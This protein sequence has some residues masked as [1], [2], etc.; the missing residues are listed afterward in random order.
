MQPWGRERRMERLWHRLGIGP[1]MPRTIY[2][3]PW[4]K[5]MSI[6]TWIALGF[7]ALAWIALVVALVAIP[8]TQRYVC[9]E[10]PAPAGYATT[11][12]ALLAAAVAAFVAIGFAAFG[13]RNVRTALIVVGLGLMPLF[14]ISPVGMVWDH[15]V[16]TGCG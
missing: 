3:E 1:T 7:V 15:H 5:R 12:W 6:T 4:R 13:I 8:F 16:V 11:L 2:M 14:A 10:S 9:L